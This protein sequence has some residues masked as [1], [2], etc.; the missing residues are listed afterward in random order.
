M[1]PLLKILCG[2]FVLLVALSF[3]YANEHANLLIDRL[4]MQYSTVG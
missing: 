4:N 2:L 3:S 1:N